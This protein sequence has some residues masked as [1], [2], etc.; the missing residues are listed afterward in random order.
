M[1]SLQMMN[2][3]LNAVIEKT[4]SDKESKSEMMKLRKELSEK[5]KIINSHLLTIEKMK[6]QLKENEIQFKPVENVPE[7]SFA[8]KQLYDENEFL[9]KK[10][11]KYQTKYIKYKAKYEQVN[12][13]LK[14]FIPKGGMLGRKRFGSHQL[15]E[16]VEEKEE[17]NNLSQIFESKEIFLANSDFGDENKEHMNNSIEEEKVPD[18]IP[19]SKKIA[20]PKKE[21]IK[22]PK[23]SPKIEPK[24][25]SKKE[26]KKE[27]KKEPK[28]PAKK[29]PKKK[30][31]KKAKSEEIEEVE[32]LE[33]EV[34]RDPLSHIY[35]IPKQKSS[36]K[37]EST[38]EQKI[39][40]F[41]N[42]IDDIDN[43]T[44]INEYINTLNIS[45]SLYE[46]VETI[47]EYTIMNSNQ[48][49]LHKFIKFIKSFIS[50]NSDNTFVY[51]KEYILTNLSI[52][53]IQAN[54]FKYNDQPLFDTNLE[55]YTNF[56]Y[57]IAYILAFFYPNKNC[58]ELII[59]LSCNYN[60]TI[61]KILHLFSTIVNHEELSENIFDNSDQILA[62]KN[63]KNKILFF[64][65][66]KNKIITNEIADTVLKYFYSFDDNMLMERFNYFIDN[67]A[68]NDLNV[69]IL[70]QIDFSKDL[71]ILNTI[72]L[73]DFMANVTTFDWIYDN[74]FD[75][76]LWSLFLS[77][78]QKRVT[79]VF[80]IS[81]ILSLYIDIEMLSNEKSLRLMN[82]VV[83]VFDPKF[84]AE[85]I[86]VYEKIVALSGFLEC[87]KLDYQ[88]SQ[89]VKR[90]LSDIISKYGDDIIPFDMMEYI[91][92]INL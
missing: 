29:E 52:I 26:P 51:F 35:P 24:K 17:K 47:L 42:F 73:I 2:T 30:K 88:I 20:K 21:S 55:S 16:Y 39:Q 82:W 63:N 85:K 87:C 22:S 9:K 19:K 92:K 89:N 75:K 12:K 86:S 81:Y 44:D 60:E 66:F 32:Q 57:I 91:K 25:E 28:K 33:I 72:Q 14:Y 71:N 77:D 64:S 50:I 74:I 5:E 13:F 80:F 6:T 18:D 49:Y 67:I 43:H 59:E 40:H 23:K 11:Q 7:H 62:F 3:Q 70:E 84:D 58:F 69:K 53:T 78:Q 76:V 8:V 48:I 1:K 65:N 46:N 79:I 83:S 38:K 45:H 4:G 61:G 41:L 15:N 56:Y 31:E 10:Y 68:Y 36:I 90:V 37:E 34:E 27:S 54:K